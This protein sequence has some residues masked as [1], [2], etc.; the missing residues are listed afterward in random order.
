ML[1]QQKEISKM[2]RSTQYYREK[3]HKYG[4][5]SRASESPDRSR[6]PVGASYVLSDI[7]RESSVAP[8]EQLEESLPTYTRGSTASE[9]TV[10]SNLST[11]QSKSSVKTDLD[12]RY[13]GHSKSLMCTK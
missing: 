12:S 11:P 2:R 9:S 5:Q 10:R 6:T 1:L 4:Q 13:T 7:E 3:I 8:S